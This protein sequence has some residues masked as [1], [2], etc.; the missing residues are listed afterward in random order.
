[1]ETA[2]PTFILAGE[3]KTG[4]PSLLRVSSRFYTRGGIYE[5]DD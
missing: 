2:K 3:Q 4:P 5:I 1:M